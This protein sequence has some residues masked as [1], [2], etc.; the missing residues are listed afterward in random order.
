MS[1][2]EETSAVLGCRGQEERRDCAA[3]DR[4]AR[5]GVWDPSTSPHPRPGTAK[6]LTESERA[7]VARFGIHPEDEEVSRG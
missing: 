6:E 1:A 2:H 5:A 7:V 3:E 4:A